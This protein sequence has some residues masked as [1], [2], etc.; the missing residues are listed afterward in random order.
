MNKPRPSIELMA[1]W[2]TANKMLEDK[3]LPALRR[4][5][6]YRYW[7]SALDQQ[8]EDNIDG[9]HRKINEWRAA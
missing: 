6:A 8:A 3:G 1:F 4:A 5:E 9:I 7:E 2:L